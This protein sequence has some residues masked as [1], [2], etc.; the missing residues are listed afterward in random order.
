MKKFLCEV[1]EELLAAVDAARGPVP[2]NPWIEAVL[3]K[4]KAIREAAE[5]VTKEM[6]QW[7]CTTMRGDK[8]MMA[9]WYGRITRVGV[10][11]RQCLK[12]AEWRPNGEGVPSWSTGT[13]GMGYGRGGTCKREQIMSMRHEEMQQRAP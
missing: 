8:T 9:K 4:I 6:L 13:A 12:P 7:R 5:S 2:R 10:A 3:W 11:M 1:S